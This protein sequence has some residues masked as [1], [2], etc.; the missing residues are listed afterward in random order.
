MQV[1]AEI[2]WFWR[3]NPPLNL[4]EWFRN[5]GA[6]NCPAGGGKER[7]DEYL[8]DPV[9][10]ELGLKHRGGKPGVEVKG[11]VAANWSSLEVEPFRG[12]V[13]LWAKWTSE[14]LVLNATVATTKTRWLRKFD[15]AGTPPLEISLDA[16]E[17][18][19]DG[20]SLP[21]VGCNVELTKVMLPNGKV[22]WTLG[23]ES[24]GAVQ[25]VANALQVTAVEIAFRK[26]PLPD[27]GLLASYPTW[28]REHVLKA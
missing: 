14:P 9:Q 22:W 6:G 19:V 20:L 2:R 4:V 21:V 24:F 18:R 13:E 10:S 1:S 27:G 15:T 7:V 8:Y 28:L 26:P 3:N 23:F 5:H 16:G 11:L 12:P 17:K 25:E